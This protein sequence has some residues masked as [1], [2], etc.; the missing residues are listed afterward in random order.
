MKNILPGRS[1]VR[2]AAAPARLCPI[3]LLPALILIFALIGCLFN[4]KF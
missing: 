1:V 3:L 2:H 4:F